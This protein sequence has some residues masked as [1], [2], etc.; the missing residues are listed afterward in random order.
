MMTFP[1][2]GNLSC[3]SGNRRRSAAS[4]PTPAYSWALNPNLQAQ[5]NAS[6]YG[7]NALG[8]AQSIY[9]LGASFGWSW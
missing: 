4:I 1:E 5:Q 8:K 7:Q 3:A 2:D 9:G 6:A